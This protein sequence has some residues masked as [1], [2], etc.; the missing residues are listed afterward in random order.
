MEGRVVAGAVLVANIS[1]PV[2]L[3]AGDDMCV[4]QGAGTGD[5]RRPRHNPVEDADGRDEM[6]TGRH[7]AD[8]RGEV[9]A[10]VLAASLSYGL[11]GTALAVTVLSLALNLLPTGVFSDAAD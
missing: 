11:A 9:G 6:A 1:R 7:L 4:S 5:F 2:V 3:D 10:G 8:D